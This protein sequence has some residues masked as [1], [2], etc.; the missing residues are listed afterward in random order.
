[1]ARLSAAVPG[2]CTRAAAGCAADIVSPPGRDGAPTEV[3]AT[4]QV[5][6]TS[7]NSIARARAEALALSTAAVA[8]GIWPPSAPI[9]DALAGLASAVVWDLHV[10]NDLHDL[11]VAS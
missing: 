4:A 8:E 3:G 7:C 2:H 6:P 1:M 10:D 9:L 5:S 11:A